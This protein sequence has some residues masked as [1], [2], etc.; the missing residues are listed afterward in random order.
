MKPKF[1]F[2]SVLFCAVG[3][4]FAQSVTEFEIQVQVGRN[5]L[6]KPGSFNVV[7]ANETGGILG[8]GTARFGKGISGGR[9][10]AGIA[11]FDNTVNLANAKY[12]QVTM[13]SQGDSVDI[14]HIMIRCGNEIPR[15]IVVDELL[16]P[17][18]NGE[19]RVF[20]AAIKDER[21]EKL[22]G[23]VARMNITD[24]LR[25]EG[26]LDL[27]VQ[28]TNGKIFLF[29]APTTG[30]LHK[31]GFTEF[32]LPFPTPVKRAEIKRIQI[33]GA[34]RGMSDGAPVLNAFYEPDDVAFEDVEFTGMRENGQFMSLLRARTLRLQNYNSYESPDLAPWQGTVSPPFR[35][36]AFNFIVRTGTDDLRHAVDAQ[37]N[38]EFNINMYVRGNPTP[39]PM[40]TRA[41]APYADFANGGV[42]G[43]SFANYRIAER[44]IV[45]SRP[46]QPPMIQD[47]ERFE[48][49]T[50]NGW[51]GST[52]TK[53]VLRGTNETRQ[54][55]EWDV[56]GLWVG[57]AE[58][59][60]AGN[61]E[62]PLSAW[63]TLVANYR[64][65]RKIGMR[66]TIPFPV[67][68]V[69]PFNIYDATIRPR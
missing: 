67:S 16:Q 65:G 56:R 28:L 32:V 11:R 35:P 27:Q 4:A 58:A 9:S 33:V 38:M 69:R 29:P 6:D 61:W 1:V 51:D 64:V 22:S 17:A 14:R 2:S 49:V 42:W 31:G 13:D 7:A 5:G 10:Q 37:P 43:G 66:Q 26:S 53:A 8:G 60:P 36:R 62:Q 57:C 54:G 3:M 30:R 23:M 63:T 52:P 68:V 40:V 46:E 48:I 39:I 55:D 15:K 47:I 18:W 59:L 19:K 25:L 41:L 34:S 20:L 44:K 21:E 50:V 24:G 12:F 45:W